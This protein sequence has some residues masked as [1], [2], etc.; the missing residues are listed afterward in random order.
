MKWM[1][2]RVRTNAESED[3]I[4]SELADIGLSGAQIED[5]VPLSS[6]EKEQMFTDDLQ[7]ADENETGLNTSARALPGE[8]DDAAI[9]SFFMELAPSGSLPGGMAPSEMTERIREVLD[10]LR[11]YS[12]IGEGTISVDVTEDIDWINNWKQ[13]FRPFSI[14][15]I[16]ILPS[17]Y[18]ASG[19]DPSAKKHSLTLRIDPGTA[20]G[21]GG[22]ESTRL[23]I[24]QL[25]KLVKKGDRLLDVGT[26]SGI[27]AVLALLLGAESA[28][29]TDLD[30]GAIPAVS[31]NLCK[32]NLPGFSGDE[33]GGKSEFISSD[34]RFKLLIGNILDDGQALQKVKDWENEYDIITANILPYVLIPLSPLIPMLLSDKGVYIASG[35]ISEKQAQVS[36]AIEKAGLQITEITNENE[37]VSITARKRV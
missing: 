24:R 11:A 10:E 22:H 34:N 31:D 36:E 6:S 25:R 14:E 9:L 8:S 3:I 35:I 16:L 20:F 30:Q 28:I 15:D 7:T 4:I 13:Y 27:L 1:R 21:T 33:T 29:G 26:G 18:E 37:W 5:N 23:V 17:W 12:D 19:E 32:N 2:F